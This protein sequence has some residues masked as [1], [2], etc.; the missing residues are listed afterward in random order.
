MEELLPLMSEFGFP[1]VVTLYLLH[2]LERKLDRVTDSIL[3]LP[4]RLDYHML[5]LKKE[6]MTR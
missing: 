3:E 6:R 5:H 1:I 4:D 2:R